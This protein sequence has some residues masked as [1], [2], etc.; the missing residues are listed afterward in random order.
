MVK[1]NMDKNKLEEALE[2]VRETI[3]QRLKEETVQRARDIQDELILEL[4]A[5]HRHYMAVYASIPPHIR[6]TVM[7]ML[8]EE[9]ED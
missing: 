7:R 2:R 8:D 6:K 9:S 5:S 4:K 3:E 1:I